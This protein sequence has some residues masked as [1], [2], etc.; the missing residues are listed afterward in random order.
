[1]DPLAILER[2]AALG[3]VL[4]A[5]VTTVA[6]LTKMDAFLLDPLAILGQNAALVS[7]LKAT[8]T[9]VAFLADSDGCLT[10]GAPCFGNSTCCKLLN[11]T[12]G[13]CLFSVESK[14]TL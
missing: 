4:K 10:V 3:S 5:T 6:F 2:N 14:D 1:M 12:G 7:V 9:T 11:C 8:V 13:H